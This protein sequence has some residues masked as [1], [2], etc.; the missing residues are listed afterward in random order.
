MKAMLEPMMVATR[1]QILVL[2]EHEVSQWPDK[3]TAASEGGFMRSGSAREWEAAGLTFETWECI[4]RGSAVTRSES[5]P[6]PGNPVLAQ[7]F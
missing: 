7:L 3:M 6:S 1:I 2:E 5:T 4:V